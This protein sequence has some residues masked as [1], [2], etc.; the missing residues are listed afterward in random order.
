MEQERPAEPDSHGSAPET[1][2]QTTRRASRRR[3]RRRGLLVPVVIG[4]VALA[5]VFVLGLV[6]GRALEDAPRP[7]GEQ[8]IVRTLIPSTIPPAEVVTVTVTEP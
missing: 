7:G 2:S 4:V 8:T 5:A 3:E 6:I 1:E